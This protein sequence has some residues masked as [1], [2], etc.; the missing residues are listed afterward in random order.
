MRIDGMKAPHPERGARARPFAGMAVAIFAAASL[1]GCEV[2]N[3]GPVDDAYISLPA[4]QEGLVL[5][6]WERLNRV[7]GNGAYDEALPAREIFPGGQTGSYG[8]GIGRQAGNMGGWTSSGPYNTAQQA[9]WIGEEA[10]R[11]FEA[12]DD[13]T[14][15]MMT[16]AYV[17]TGYANRINGDFYCWGVIDSG[18]LVEGRH[19]WERAATNFT[20]AI[21]I[22]P[23]DELRQAA[24]AGRAQARLS[25]EDWAGALSDAQQVSDAFEYHVAMD[26][27]RGGNT[28][29]RNHIF[30]AAA[31]I[32]YR[33]FTVRFTF[34]DDYYTESGDP[35]TPWAAFVKEESAVCAGALSGYGRVPC[36]QQLKYQSQDDD[37]RVAS[38]GEMRLV[39]AEAMLRMNPGSWQAAMGVINANRARHI[40]DVSELPLEPWTAT[41]LD[42][43][44]TILK[45]ERGI[46]LWLEA[47][48]FAD[49]R[50]WEP[51]ILE[52][53]T[54]AADGQTVLPLESRTPGTLDWP[55][56]EGQMPDPEAN[57][58]TTNL[59]GRSAIEDQSIPREYCYNISGTERSNNPNFDDNGDPIVP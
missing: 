29:Q 55:D 18:P 52:Y 32:P 27:S 50:R 2:V 44:W 39:E 16:M 45:R 13:V 49:L 35:R 10:V 31:D 34:Y 7:V 26:F 24:Y 1:G 4:S 22:A 17:A 40:S 20:S 8:Q 25:L 6:S 19:Y 21:A 51:Y 28:A 42:E 56:F 41:S 57:M 15:E 9:R 54:L 38:G 37:I 46:E 30:W 36:T 14:P 3:P 43:A 33:S 23:N 47:R 58:F 11:Q 12:R 59:R 53:G 5:G 48:R